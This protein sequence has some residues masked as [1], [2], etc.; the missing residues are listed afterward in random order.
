[1]GGDTWL[2]CRATGGCKSGRMTCT[3]APPAG[4]SQPSLWIRAV[5]S[6]NS[7]T[8][9]HRCLAR[10]LRVL[11]MS[12][13]GGSPRAWVAAVD[14]VGIGCSRLSFHPISAGSLTPSRPAPPAPHRRPTDPLPPAPYS[15]IGAT[16]GAPDAFAAGFI[17]SGTVIIKEEGGF[18]SWLWKTKWVVLR[19]QTISIHKS[20]VRAPLS[21]LAPPSPPRASSRRRRSSS[22]SATS[23]TS[24]ASISSPTVFYSSQR[25]S[26]S[27]YLSKA[28]RSSTAGRTTSTPAHPWELSA[29]P[30]LS[31]KSTSGSTLSQ[32]RSRCV[33][34]P[35]PCIITLLT[36]HTPP[37]HARSVGEIAHQVQHHKGRLR[38]RPAGRARRARVL[39]GSSKTGIG[40]SRSS[41]SRHG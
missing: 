28:T 10:T 21:C 37:G 29:P 14:S 3:C 40:G 24:S 2:H 38:Q 22:T 7:Y 16:P 36:P 4:A 11:Y 6:P 18:S 20:E 17:R 23:P 9:S 34:V 39:H 12:S 25:T 27:I 30:I 33:C 15:G 32:A 31:P 26:A 8:S 1:M 13:P 19:E 41:A 5:G 35:V